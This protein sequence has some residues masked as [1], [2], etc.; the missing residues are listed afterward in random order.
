MGIALHV[1]RTPFSI[2]YMELHEAGKLTQFAGMAHI[3]NTVSQE[4]VAPNSRTVTNAMAA[5]L[6]EFSAPNSTLEVEPLDPQDPDSYYLTRFAYWYIR[7]R[8]QNSL[9]PALRRTRCAN[10]YSRH[11][12][13]DGSESVMRPTVQDEEGIP[14]ASA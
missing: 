7:T 1:L 5:F 6:H 8:M 14:G 13:R 4:P 2:G 3:I 9:Q 12:P 10:P 11:Q